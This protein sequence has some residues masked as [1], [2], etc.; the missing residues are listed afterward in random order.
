MDI[1]KHRFRE[2][3]VDN[4]LKDNGVFTWFEP[5]GCNYFVYENIISEIVDV[6]P[7]NCSYYN[8]TYAV[9]PYYI[10]SK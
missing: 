6:N 10:N 7:I 8:L 1:N 5:T 9:C 3:I 4:S 2:L